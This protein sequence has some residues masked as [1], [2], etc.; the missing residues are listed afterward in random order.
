MIE[1]ATNLVATGGYLGVFLL[2][3][4]ENLFPP[5]PSEVIMSLAGFAAAQG[6]LTLLGV[7]LAGTLGAIVGNAAWYEG[8][9]IFGAAR[10]R[11]LLTRF[12]RYVGI[13]E[14]E[15]HK[16][17][18]TMRAKGPVAVF[19]G[20]FMPGIRTAIS[21]PAGLIELPRPVFYVWTGLGSA[22]WTAGLAIAGY[23]LEEQFGAVEKF[24][25]PIGLA[26]L[27]VGVALVALQVWKALR[28]RRAG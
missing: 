13:T 28:A 25:G 1:W 24:A 7:V 21:I 4:L 10:T 26:F 5:I 23:L 11:A 20:R 22:I 6:K 3:V 27:A 12:G 18:A 9:R 14:E 15:V 17:E 8:A 16:A 19:L 2:M